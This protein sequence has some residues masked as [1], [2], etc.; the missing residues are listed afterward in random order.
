MAVYFAFLEGQTVNSE[1]DL[2]S[3]HVDNYNVVQ[4]YLSGRPLTQQTRASPYASI[5]ILGKKS[6]CPEGAI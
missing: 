4:F 1:C 2:L 5:V 3:A 6:K